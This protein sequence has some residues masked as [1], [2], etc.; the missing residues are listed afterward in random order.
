MGKVYVGM[1][2]ECVGRMGNREVGDVE[3]ERKI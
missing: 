1:G 3:E 2:G